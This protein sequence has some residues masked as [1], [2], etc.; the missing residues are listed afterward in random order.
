MRWEWD[1][2]SAFHSLS[3]PVAGVLGAW[4][5]PLA[6]EETFAAVEGDLAQEVGE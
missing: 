6:G 5:E 3:V 2:A 1:A 4:R